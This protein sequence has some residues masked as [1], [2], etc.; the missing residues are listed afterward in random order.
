MSHKT[1]RNQWISKCSSFQDASET[2]AY[3]HMAG[4]RV[5][6]STS[7]LTMKSKPCVQP[8]ERNFHL[9]PRVSRAMLM[10]LIWIIKRYYNKLSQGGCHFCQ[11]LSSSN[12]ARLLLTP[13][14]SP[15]K[16]NEAANCCGNKLQACV[17]SKPRSISWCKQMYFFSS[18][19]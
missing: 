16:K 7:A 11:L 6:S 9:L 10:S 8:S 19:T 14:S 2:K 13:S 3:E 5:S 18:C 4:M 12:T 17:F 1:L 15:A